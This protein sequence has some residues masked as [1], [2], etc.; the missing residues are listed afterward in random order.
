MA[1]VD[2]VYDQI[3]HRHDPRWSAD[4]GAGHD[5]GAWANLRVCVACV[6]ELIDSRDVS[7]KMLNVIKFIRLLL[8]VELKSK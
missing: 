1:S 8:F 6:V 2:V 5:A 7:V 4:A 3:H